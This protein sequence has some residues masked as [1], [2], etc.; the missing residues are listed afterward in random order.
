MHRLK[1]KNKSF[2]IYIMATTLFLESQIILNSD[3]LVETIETQSKSIAV[4]LIQN[5]PRWISCGR[6]SG[7][8]SGRVLV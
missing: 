5:I 7:V 8:V 6:A 1:I 3:F 2:K 4:S